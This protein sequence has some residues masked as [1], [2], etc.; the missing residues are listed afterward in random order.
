MIGQKKLL[1]T[2]KTSKLPHFIILVSPQGSG[3]KMVARHIAKLLSATYAPCGIKVD[4]VRETI[5]TAMHVTEKMLYCIE[6]ADNMSLMAKN[7]LL[8]ITEEPP[9][10]AY[11]IMTVQNDG[12]VL[13]TIKSR[14]TVIH[15]DPYTPSEIREYLGTIQGQSDYDIDL[16]CDIATTPYQAEL[17]FRYGKDFTDYVNLVIDNI[18]EVEP[19][20]AFKSSKALSFKKED[21]E[22]YDLTL[23]WST[24][25]ALCVK[26]MK[27]DPLHFSQGIEVT[28]PYITRS[29]KVGVN[30]QQLYDSWVFKIRE[31]WL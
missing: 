29:M 18:A 7:A 24:F 23:F 5:D 3:K 15:L 25:N 11:F 28:S 17:L 22:H 10:N 6:D 20:N 30:L 12:S 1:N 16:A 4:E 27:E 19:A 21:T 8:K 2:L 14:G 13:G 31:A 26:R 9:E